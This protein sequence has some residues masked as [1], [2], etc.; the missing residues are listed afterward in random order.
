[1]T[2]TAGAQCQRFNSP[3]T[4]EHH[5]LMGRARCTIFMHVCDLFSQRTYSSTYSAKNSPHTAKIAI[6][7]CSL[8]RHACALR[9][10]LRLIFSITPSTEEARHMDRRNGN[11]G[12]AGGR[13]GPETRRQNEED[14]TNKKEHKHLPQD[15]T[16]NTYIT[17]G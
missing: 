7:L 13:G 5:T 17:A 9:V 1:M 12:R 2:E 16:K 3:T 10:S 14:R 15:I 6:S 4:P 8:Y 11:G